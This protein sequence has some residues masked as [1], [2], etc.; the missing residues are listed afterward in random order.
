MRRRR[1]VILGAPGAGKTTLAV[2]LVRGLLATRAQPGNQDEPV[3]VLL[4]VADWDITRFPRLQD[5]VTARLAQDYPP[6]RSPGLGAQV[7]GVLARRGQ[8]LPVLDGLDE[9]PDPAQAMVIAALNRSLGG[10]DQVI[11]TSRTAEYARA[12][13]AGADVL[14]SAAVIEPDPVSPAEAAPGPA[15]PAAAVAEIASTPLGLWLLR[16]T[17]I[18]LDAILY[19]D[20]QALRAHL[21]DQLIPALVTTRTPGD[22]PADLFRPRRRHAPEDVRRW[23]GYLARHMSRTAAGDRDTSGAR[24]FQWWRLASGTRAVTRRARYSLG[25]AL[26]L[27][28]FLSIGCFATR[29]SMDYPLLVGYVLL[30]LA[31]AAW[32][33]QAPGPRRPRD[34]ARMTGL[35]RRLAGGLAPVFGDQAVQVV[36]PSAGRLT[37]AFEGGQAVLNVALLAAEVTLAARAWEDQPPGHA[38]LR[39]TGRSRQLARALSGGTISGLGIGLAF[40]LLFTPALT[41]ASWSGSWL[42]NVLDGAIICCGYP[43]TASDIAAPLLSLT[44]LGVT[45]GLAGG[46]TAWAEAPAR[47]SQAVTPLASWRAD[48][49]LTLTRTASATLLFTTAIVLFRVF[50]V[51]YFPQDTEGPALLLSLIPGT[52]IGLLAA[53]ATGNHHAWVA[54]LIATR[55]LARKNCLPRSLMPFLDDAHR[56]GLLRAVGPTYQFRHAELQDHLAAAY[57]PSRAPGRQSTLIQSTRVLRRN[58]ARTR[59]TALHPNHT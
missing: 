9:L 11:L 21:L 39:V 5:W 13:E 44:P 46:L 58:R 36:L 1:L 17:Y 24:D 15:G 48:R 3:P 51:G 25:L 45:L 7:P 19:P 32:A 56:L 6:L 18:L 10:G 42:A 28:S 47:T 59:S 33:Q 8:V 2:Q 53:L 35:G 23:L 52:A 38:D 49:R 14:T 16:T 20:T 4:S 41:L 54:Y 57:R 31:A 22:D 55:R 27:A 26:G 29:A 30:L 50:P 34:P 43:L 12:V 37:P 40:A